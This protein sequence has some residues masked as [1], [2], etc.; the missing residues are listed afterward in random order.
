MMIA[1]A[2]RLKTLST[3]LWTAGLVL[4][5]DAIAALG[6]APGL[7]KLGPMQVEIDHEKATLQGTNTLAGRL[8]S[9]INIGISIKLRM[10]INS[11]WKLNGNLYLSFCIYSKALEC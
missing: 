7:H 1:F 8:L 5:T 11:V 9:L 3:P 4:I 10:T 2:Q 6:L